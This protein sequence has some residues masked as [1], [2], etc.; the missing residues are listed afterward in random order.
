MGPAGGGAEATRAAPPRGD[1][2]AEGRGELSVRVRVQAW[3]PGWGGGSREDDRERLEGEQRGGRRGEEKEGRREQGAE[4]T[5][6]RGGSR[7]GPLAAPSPGGS[8]A[9][10]CSP[11]LQ[12]A[13]RSP[14]ASCPARPARASPL[15]R[16]PGPARHPGAMSAATAPER[17]WKSEKVDEAQAL[18]RSCAARRP[19][20]QPCDGLSICATHSH[21][22]CFKLHWCCHLGWCHCKWSRVG[23]RSPACD[24]ALPGRREAIPGEPS[25][26]HKR[27]PSYPREPGSGFLCLSFIYLLGG[28][29][30]S[31]A[32]ARLQGSLFS[33]G[34]GTGMPLHFL[35]CSFWLL[36]NRKSPRSS[37]FPFIYRIQTEEEPE[38]EGWRLRS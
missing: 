31:R 12:P 27:G 21:G 36:L 34:G 5:R 23:L 6:A 35:A 24:P 37:R 3:R 25:C 28:G 20:F 9:S 17:G 7:P 29:R 30:T 13:A 11:R 8:S 15:S 16:A 22:K 26:S 38:Y 2:L 14:P 10:R 18:A 1:G 19:D 32:N 33:S 4:G